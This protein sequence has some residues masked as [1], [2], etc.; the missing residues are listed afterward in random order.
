[1]KTKSAFEMYIDDIKDIPVLSKEE[2]EKLVNDMMNGD[3]TA[4]EKLITHNLKLVVHIVRN[5]YA[6][7]GFDIMELIQQGNLGL[8]YGID[9]YDPSRNTALNTAIGFGIKHYINK[10]RYNQI[11]LI[12][13]PQYHKELSVKMKYAISALEQLYG[14]QPTDEDIAD[15]LNVPVETVTR[16][17]LDD[18]IRFVSIDELIG[19]DSNETIGDQ[20]A[21][22]TEFTNYEALKRASD[23][24]M[25]FLDPDEQKL[26]RE[27][28]GL[29]E[30]E[31]KSLEEIAKETPYTKQNIGLIKNRTITKLRYPD[32]LKEIRKQL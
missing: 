3:K 31:S 16:N 26:M 8:I 6:G 18:A 27:Y 30:T 29:G 23:L 28:Y 13:K 32:I 19:D 5:Q 17:R 2:T 24:A 14:E 1:M 15:Y 4:R 11:D 12:R 25:T 7:K 22:E 10:Y 21:D 20:I 9:H